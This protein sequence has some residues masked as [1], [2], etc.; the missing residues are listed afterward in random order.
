MLVGKRQVGTR[1]EDAHHIFEDGC[2]LKC[3]INCSTSAR[4]NSM[5]KRLIAAGAVVTQD[6]DTDGIVLFDAR[7]ETLSRLV[8]KLAGVRIKRNISDE[9]RAAIKARFANRR[10][11]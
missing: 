10:K 1:S 6:G 2:F 4:W 5:R 8:I 9:Q 3:Y 7:D 11:V